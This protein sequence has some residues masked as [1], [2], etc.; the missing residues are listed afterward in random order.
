[1]AAPCV[2]LSNEQ[3]MPILAL[4]T[5]QLPPGEIEKII[6]IAIN[7][8]YRH[9]DCALAYSN[10]SEIGAALR[11]KISEGVVKREE[12]FIVSKLWNT[13]HE[14]EN[15]VPACKN[16]LESFGFDYIDLYLIHWPVAQKNLGHAINRQNPF[17]N[18]I[19][20]DY[21]YVETWKGM[22]DCVAL[23]LTKGIG[24][25]NFNSKQI[26]RILQNSII[27]PLVNQIEVTPTFNQK[28]LI[29]FCK[30]RNICVAAYRP[31]EASTKTLT[32]PHNTNFSLGNQKLVSIGKKYGKTAAQVVLRYLIEIGTIPIP[33]S[34]NE[35]RI[36]ENIDVFNFQLD[37]E[38]LQILDGFNR[39]SRVFFANELKDM[40][41]YPFSEDVKY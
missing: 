7:A 6:E 38:D 40:P 41:H 19:G 27:K 37:E 21:D 26:H 14:R 3:N 32:D 29:Q 11:K 1:M 39:D 12:L 15:V 2:T 30:E 8:G 20:L 28:K 23:G 33:K 10:E 36:H 13:F 17:H 16:C 22:E 34:T 25:S 9:F 24:L 18:A 5:W 31:F 4:G 35:D